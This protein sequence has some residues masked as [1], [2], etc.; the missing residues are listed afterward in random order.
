MISKDYYKILEI[1]P[2]ATIAEI[3]KA[4]RRLALLYH[5]DRNFGSNMHEAKFKEIKEAYDVLS[6]VSR[7]Q[8]YN[9]Q[10]NTRQ[11][12]PEKKKTYHQPAAETI[13]A[14]ITD[15]SKK[16]AALDPDRMNKR[17]LYEQIQHLLVIH[18]ILVLK[19]QNDLKIN[20]RVI[21]EILF[22]AQFLPYPYAQKICQQL[23][24]LA[25]T[26]NETYSKIYNFLKEARFRSFWNK[27]KFAAAIIVAIILCILIY[28]L[29]TTF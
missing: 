1:G 3:K 28:V 14:Q 12:Q 20:K 9:R 15:L 23:R 16:T 10:R 5:P 11:Q 13:L 4:F 18:N 21:D 25:G 22:C 19:H 6:N 8:E 27:Y 29:S 17:A 26:D 24:E 2:A 7:R